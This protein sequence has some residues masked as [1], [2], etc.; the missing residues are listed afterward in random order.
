[1][2]FKKSYYHL[3]FSIIYFSNK[4]LVSENHTTNDVMFYLSIYAGF[5]LLN[6]IFTLIRAF[7]FAYGGVQGA[8][9]IHKSLLNVVIKVIF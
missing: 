2:V 1:M 3:K 9:S 6:S 7:M 5:A 8:I 4:I